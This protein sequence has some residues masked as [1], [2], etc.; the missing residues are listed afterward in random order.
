MTDQSMHEIE[1][2]TYEFLKRK[3]FKL[4]G[5]G[6]NHRNKL[7]NLEVV[8]EKGRLYLVEIKQNV[9]T[10]SYRNLIYQ[11]VGLSHVRKAHG[12]IIVSTTSIP[13][14]IEKEITQN[15]GLKFL[16]YDIADIVESVQESGIRNRAL[17][18]IYAKRQDSTLQSP[19][20]RRSF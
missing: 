10:K 3:G 18:K 4:H 20:G 7:A 1:Q 2:K 17:S 9:S 19:A 14:I 6:V 8:D 5:E 15:T 12:I 16:F 11:L 13:N